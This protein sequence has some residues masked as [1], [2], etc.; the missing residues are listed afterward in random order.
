MFMR[1]W[2]NLYFFRASE[3]VFIIYKD[4]MS[5]WHE[6]MLCKIEKKMQELNQFQW[7]I[8]TTLWNKKKVQQNRQSYLRNE[9]QEREFLM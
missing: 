1:S 4:N 6:I 5:L 8:P 9:E 7:V 2:Q 3:Y